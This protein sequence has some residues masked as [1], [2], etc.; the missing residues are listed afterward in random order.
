M[1]AAL[2]VLFAVADTLDPAARGVWVSLDSVVAESK[3]LPTTTL[4][5]RLTITDSTLAVLEVSVITDAGDGFFGATEAAYDVEADGLVL[6]GGGQ[7]WS[8]RVEGDSLWTVLEGERRVRRVPPGRRRP[9][10]R[11]AGPV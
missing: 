7:T 6:E 10:R 5:H 2:L 1:L 11:V 8:L 4:A 9:P 3:P